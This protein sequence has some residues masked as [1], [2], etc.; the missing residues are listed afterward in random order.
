MQDAEEECIGPNLPTHIFF[1]IPD[2]AS[3]CPLM[4]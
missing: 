3:N 2:P 1:R 4:E